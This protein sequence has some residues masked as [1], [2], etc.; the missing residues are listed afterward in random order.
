MFWL[1]EIFPSTHSFQHPLLSM[2]VIVKL[3]EAQDSEMSEQ[4]IILD[5]VMIQKTAIRAAHALIV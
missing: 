2:S 4:T 3:V 5:G 1:V